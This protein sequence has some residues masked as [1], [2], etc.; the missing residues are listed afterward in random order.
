MALWKQWL[1]II[2]LLVAYEV[3]VICR[4]LYLWNDFGRNSHFLNGNSLYHR[5]LSLP[6]RRT[7]LTKRA[8]LLDIL[9]PLETAWEFYCNR[10]DILLEMVQRGA[11][12]AKKNSVRAAGTLLIAC[13]VAQILALVGVLGDRG[14]GLVPYFRENERVKEYGVERVLQKTAA[15][16]TTAG[17]K[18]FKTCRR[19]GNTSKFAVS[20]S[21]GALFSSAAVNATTLSVKMFISTFLVVEGLSFAGVI[22]EPGESILE[23]IDSHQ[24]KS[25]WVKRTKEVRDAVRKNVSFD[26]LE[27]FYE[28]AVDEEKVACMG[29]AMGS[30]I[31]MF[32]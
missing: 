24:R 2:L 1:L 21:V 12:F 16:I 5:S 13:S 3:P 23:W 14:E 17:V 15:G 19:M 22:G 11:S 10:D 4:P 27:T 32:T 9:E 20:V 25:E 26:A 18:T 31:S 29:F 7:S 28:A 30:I 8:L 6:P